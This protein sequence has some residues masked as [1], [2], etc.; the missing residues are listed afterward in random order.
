MSHILV[1]VLGLLA[2][3]FL[4]AVIHR[5][6][7]GRSILEKSSRCPKCGH[8]LST[9]DL[10]PVLSFF[11]LGRKCRYCKKPISWQYPA[12]E[13]AT[14][15]AFVLVYYQFSPSPILPH[16]GGGMLSFIFPPLV[17]GIKGGVE[18]LFNF[19]F[20]SFLIVIFVY[21]LKH[22]L[23]LDKIVFPAAALAAVYQI[24][25]GNFVN[26]LIGAAVLSGF[27]GLLYFLS[28]GRWIGFGDV[29]LGIFL[30]LLVPWPETVVLFFL[31][32]LIGAIVGIVL[33]AYGAKA[34]QDRLPFGTFLT[35]AAFLAMLW[36][37]RLVEWYFR[38]IG[39]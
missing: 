9:L 33:I 15:L 34:L 11:V 39:L 14:G 3:S 38:L 37:E 6:H 10:I 24:W 2:G 8:E 1:F 7:S 27:F 32:Y 4:N 5:L 16:Q 19:T 26:A 30:G 17:G 12:V 28:K 23:I 31:A 35:L 36:G 21:D 29:K 25:Q 20:I 13:L 18:L 22:Y